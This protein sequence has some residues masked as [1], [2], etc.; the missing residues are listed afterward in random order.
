MTSRH[1][2]WG[3]VC[4][5]CWQDGRAQRT[6]LSPTLREREREPVLKGRR[7]WN[8]AEAA[9]ATEAP[10]LEADSREGA[11]GSVNSEPRRRDEQSAHQQLGA[12]KH[13]RFPCDGRHSKPHAVIWVNR[14]TEIP[15]DR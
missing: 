10:L 8:E 6:V 13:V 12:R 15:N 2:H 7:P 5:S 1:S 11:H 4:T 3:E 14:T 9:Q